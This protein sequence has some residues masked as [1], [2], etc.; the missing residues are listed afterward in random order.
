MSGVGA[1]QDKGCELSGEVRGGFPDLSVGAVGDEDE[2]TVR[3]EL[4]VSDGLLEVEVVQHCGLFVVDE[5]RSAV[6]K[7]KKKEVQ[8]E[9]TKMCDRGGGWLKLDFTF[10]YAEEDVGVGAEGDA[11]D[12]LPVLKRERAGGVVDQIKDADAVANW[13]EDGVAVC[14]EQE[15]AFTV[16]GADEVVELEGG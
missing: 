8:C 12:W 2:A 11:G 15:V 5:K 4:S 3:A 13:R 14:S 16:D 9:D 6:Y 7:Q 10:V 1:M